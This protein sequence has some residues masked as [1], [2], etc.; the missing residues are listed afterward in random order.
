MWE[1]G[2]V[3]A[4]DGDTT[5]EYHAKVY[6]EPSELYGLNEGRVSKL[7]IRKAGEI[8]WLV[9][10]DRGWDIRPATKELENIVNVILAKYQ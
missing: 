4:V 3:A 7:A 2:R 10:Y 9:N 6:D 5:Y 1:K 8:K